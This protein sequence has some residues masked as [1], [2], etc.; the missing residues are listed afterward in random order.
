VIALRGLWAHQG[1]T[2]ARYVFPVQLLLLFWIAVG[3][4]DLAKRFLR[5]RRRSPS[6]E[7]PRP[8]SRLISGIN[9]AIVQVLTLG[10]WYG[11]AYHNFDYVLAHNRVAFYHEPGRARPSFYRKLGAMAGREPNW[12]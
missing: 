10:P 6:W 11:H 3:A 9:P 4:I 1:H 5:E 2:F 8:W 12:R 7:S